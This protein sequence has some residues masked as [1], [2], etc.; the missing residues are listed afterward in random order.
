MLGMGGCGAKS[1]E[2]NPGD[3]AA[4]RTEQTT[5]DGRV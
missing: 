5:G 4:L 1:L 2:S 3:E